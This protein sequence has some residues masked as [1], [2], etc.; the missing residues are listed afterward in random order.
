MK[1]TTTTDLLTHLCDQMKKLSVKVIT[2]EEAAAQMNLVKQANNLL[3]YELEKAKALHKYEGL[4]ITEITEKDL[5][6]RKDK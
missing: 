2:P 6:V 4:Q 3:K 5:F 1:G